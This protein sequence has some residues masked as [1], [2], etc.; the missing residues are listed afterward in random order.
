MPAHG[1]VTEEE[2]K[3]LGSLATIINKRSM[4]LVTT[5]AFESTRPL[6]NLGA[7]GLI[8]LMP[9]LNTIFNKAETEKYVK[10]LENP[11]AVSFFIDQLDPDGASPAE[12]PVKEQDHVK[13]RP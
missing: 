10:I 3:I 12:K 13:E 9:I 11:K 2:K 8:F 7:Q 4:G 5:L 1:E 6:H